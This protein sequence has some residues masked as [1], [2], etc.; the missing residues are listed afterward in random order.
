MSDQEAPVGSEPLQP[1][2]LDRVITESATSVHW[3][4]YEWPLAL[5]LV[6]SIYIHEMGHVAMLRR[7]G[8]DSSAPMFIPGVGALFNAG[9]HAING[10]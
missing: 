7:L 10:G 4:V 8:I 9:A 3:S 5:G 1:L 6:L 2:Q